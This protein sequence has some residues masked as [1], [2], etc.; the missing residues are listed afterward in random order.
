MLNPSR[1]LVISFALVALA[2]L[3][4]GLATDVGLFGW[5]VAA[6]LTLYLAA[7]GLTFIA[8]GLLE[9]EATDGSTAA[10][11]ASAESN[12]AVPS[13]SQKRRPSS[14]TRGWGRITCKSSAIPWGTSASRERR[15]TCTTSSGST[16]Q[17]DQEKT[18]M[19]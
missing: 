11:A 19:S 13:A 9:E 1:R 8:Q 3:V 17:S 5:S 18:T 14:S 7:A 10:R 6:L 2:S 12:S 15:R 4:L 16:H